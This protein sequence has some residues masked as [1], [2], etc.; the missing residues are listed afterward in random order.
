MMI[1]E[2]ESERCAEAR[3]AERRG[4]VAILLAC[5][6]GCLSGIGI[7]YAYR[8]EPSVSPQIGISVR[9]LSNI[10]CI[11]TLALLTREWPLVR[12]WRSGR[13]IWM[14]GLFGALTVVTYY[15]ATTQIGAGRS[16]I[17]NA[18]S[19]LAIAVLAPWIAGQSVSVVHAVGIVGSLF[20]M[21]LLSTSSEGAQAQ[22]GTV[23]ALASGFFAALAYLMVARSRQEFGASE[24][25]LHWM[26]ASSVACA[27]LFISIPTVLPQ[28]SVTWIVLIMTG[29]L[30]AWAQFFT[31]RA[32]QIAPA[33]LV[34]C[35]SFAGPL[36]NLLVDIYLFE[37][38]IST[39]GLVGAAMICC[40]GIAIPLIL[41]FRSGRFLELAV[42]RSI[43]YK[44]LKTAIHRSAKG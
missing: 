37:L 19:G 29:F 8:F 4:V 32:Y 1:M 35:L 17:L 20:G 2:T 44:S 21:G 15:L 9:V 18:G 40:C 42:E 27:A 24:I 25:L 10:F 31:I 14:W 33:A 43:M 41:V 30:M 16:A 36:F 6:L 12:S 28:H 7:F 39:S 22:F 13:V 5:A 26:I 38:P 3:A 23:L 34:A 11:V